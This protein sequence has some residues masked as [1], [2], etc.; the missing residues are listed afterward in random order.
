MRRQFLAFRDLV[1]GRVVAVHALVELPE[2]VG[3]DRHM[4]HRRLLPVPLGKVR[5]F[6]EEFGVGDTALGIGVQRV[7]EQG[8]AAQALVHEIRILAKFDALIE[9][10][11]QHIVE[12]V[13]RNGENHRR[14]DHQ[15]GDKQ[16]LLVPQRGIRKLPDRESVEL[17]LP[18]SANREKRKQGRQEGDG[19]NERGADTE[20]DEV[21]EIAVGRHLGKIH[22]QEPERCREARQEHRM[23]VET[24]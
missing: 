5:N 2:G 19:E 24:E 12:L 21:A 4:A 20:G 14:H 13:A 11:N 18:C 7:L 9:E 6:G 3:D 1:L 23:Q 15:P 22:A 16:R 8:I 17:P 10:M